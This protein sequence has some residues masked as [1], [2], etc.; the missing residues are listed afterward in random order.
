MEN[1]NVSNSDDF[2]LMLTNI[3]SYAEEHGGSF[4]LFAKSIIEPPF[5]AQVTVNGNSL[6]EFVSDNASYYRRKLRDLL[7]ADEN[8]D[9]FSSAQVLDKL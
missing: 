3:C 7:E 1:T 9:F 4:Q 5:V 8:D 2:N 6:H